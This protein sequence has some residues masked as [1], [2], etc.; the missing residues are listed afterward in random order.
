[1][2][3]LSLRMLGEAAVAR[4]EDDAVFH[5][6][7]LLWPLRNSVWEIARPDGDEYRED[8]LGGAAGPVE[9]YMLDHRRRLASGLRAQ[10]YRFREWPS[11]AEL[12][13]MILAA[14][15]AEGEVVG[16]DE[17]LGGGRRRERRNVVGPS[18][19]EVAGGPQ[20]D[21]PWIAMEGY[22]D[23][24]SGVEMLKIGEEVQSDLLVFRGGACG[25]ARIGGVGEVAV[26]RGG[27]RSDAAVVGPVDEPPEC[28][29]VPDGGDTQEEVDAR[30]LPVVFD[31]QGE[32]YRPW[33]E[34]VPLLETDECSDWPVEGPRT[35]LWLMKQFSRA[36]LGPQQWLERFLSTSRWS[37]IDRSVHELKALSR[38]FETGGTYD[39][40]N[41]AGLAMVE[42]MSR[43]WQTIMEAPAENPVQPDDEAA[44]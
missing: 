29:R 12:R 2:A 18:A 34:V 20:R 41:L 44:D 8:L 42:E 3:W 22:R 13:R 32:R 10:V 23:P 40:V 28:G 5:E 14:R 1:M 26:R 27:G 24:S 9:S 21:L 7:L 38:Y 39:Q 6:R 30:I 35:I 31:D 25:V 33:R 36:N 4:N 11:D 19:G 37:D 43:R 15:V 17:F 16:F